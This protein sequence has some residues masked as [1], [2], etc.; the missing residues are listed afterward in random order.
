MDKGDKKEKLIVQSICLLL[1]IGLWFYITNVENSIKTITVENINVDLI[2]SDQLKNV[3]MALSSNQEL[4]VDL[5]VEGQTSEIYKINKDQFILEAELSDYAL[6][7][8]ENRIPVK[9][10]DYPTSINIKNTNYLF[11]KLNLDEYK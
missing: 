7:I 11:V 3:G 5:K 10:V 4:E 2:S 8:G 6:K 1:S 9:V